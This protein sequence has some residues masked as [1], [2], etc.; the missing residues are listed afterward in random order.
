LLF[1]NSPIFIFFKF[2]NENKLV[3]RVIIEFPEH[4]KYEPQLID[5]GEG[6]QEE[7]ELTLEDKVFSQKNPEV[8]LFIPELSNWFNITAGETKLKIAELEVPAFQSYTFRLEDVT[9]AGLYVVHPRNN[10]LKRYSIADG[11]GEAIKSRMAHFAAVDSSI[12]G[13]TDFAFYS[14]LMEKNSDTMMYFGV[15]STHGILY[16]NVLDT[17]EKLFER[18]CDALNSPCL[19]YIINQ[20][21]D[22]KKSRRNTVEESINYLNDSLEDIAVFSYKPSAENMIEPPSAAFSPA[23]GRN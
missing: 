22:A 8:W 21:A 4:M 9:T 10:E 12:P 19:A 20:S 6:N 18:Y 13:R 5:I 23:F 2:S 1:Q 3:P 15:V 11:Y 7:G 14:K 16:V 17:S